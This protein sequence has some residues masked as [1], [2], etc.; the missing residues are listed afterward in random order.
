MMKED[1]ILRKK[2]YVVGEADKRRRLNRIIVCKGKADCH[3]DRNDDE[4]GKQNQIRRK[5]EIRRVF[6]GSHCTC[7]ASFFNLYSLMIFVI[8]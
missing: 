2:I 1:G 4:Y 6:T 5:K 7:S 3:Y 8:L